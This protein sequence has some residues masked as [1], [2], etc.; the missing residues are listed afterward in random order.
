MKMKK[1]IGVVQSV[2][3]K[4]EADTGF[5]ERG[6][7]G[8]HG[9]GYFILGHFVAGHITRCM[10]NILGDKTSVKIARGDK[11]LAILWNRE[12][13]MP[14]LSKHFIYDTDDQVN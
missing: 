4:S 9:Y 14:I 3:G 12:A 8:C 11:M 5:R 13:K 1:S 6:G 7:V 2:S 10:D